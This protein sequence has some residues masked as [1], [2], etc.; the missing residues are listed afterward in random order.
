MK[1]HLKKPT[2]EA[3]G[4]DTLITHRSPSHSNPHIPLD[5]FQIQKVGKKIMLYSFVTATGESV[6]AETE[7]FD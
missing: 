2:L 5:F 1:S 6:I 4:I 7:R 3:P